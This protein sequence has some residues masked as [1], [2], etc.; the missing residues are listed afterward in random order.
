MNSPESILWKHGEI[1]TRRI[2]HF[3]SR[4]VSPSSLPYFDVGSVAEL[5]LSNLAL[6][7]RPVGRLDNHRIVRGSLLDR[8]HDVG[9]FI[10]VSAKDRRPDR[11]AVLA[12]SG[13]PLIDPRD[14]HL[15]RRGHRI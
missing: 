7:L 10:Q 4:I 2:S 14:L 11:M 15:P 12:Q 1:R 9:K 3:G 5:L 6:A 8:Y 13:L